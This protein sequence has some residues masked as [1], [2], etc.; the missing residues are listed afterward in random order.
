M[1]SNFFDDL[2]VGDVSRIPLRKI[3]LRTEISFNFRT[4]KM[5][6]RKFWS[7]RRKKRLGRRRCEA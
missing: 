6:I 4:G 1:R 3:K 7:T 5:N 2:A